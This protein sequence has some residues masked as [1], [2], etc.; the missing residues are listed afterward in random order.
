MSVCIYIDVVAVS[1]CVIPHRLDPKA[2]VSGRVTA[3]TSKNID[4]E[5]YIYVDFVA[6]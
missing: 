3:T 6:L 2:L 5:M 4:V 1:L